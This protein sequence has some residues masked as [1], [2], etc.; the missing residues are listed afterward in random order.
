VP[1][2]WV[3]LTIG[4]TGGIA[5]GKTTVSRMFEHAGIPVICLDEL[6]RY[7]VKPGSPA[8][9]EIRRLFGDEVIDEAGEL[10]RA[11][12]A[13]IVFQDDGKRKL[14]ESIIHPKVNEEMTRR[15]VELEHL[16]HRT[17]VVDV[18]LLYEVRWEGAFDLVVVVYV[19]RQT[20]EERLMARDAMSREEA[21]SRLDAQMSIEEKR[22]RADYV[23]EN[24]DSL[25]RTRDQVTSIVRDLKKREAVK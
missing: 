18:P 14:L 11:A 15:A 13:G 25:D 17:V 12:V 5:S 10:D 1:R 20:Q 4:L 22:R 8:L 6:A 19:P 7:V 9:E 3:V 2:R 16:G 24:T 23:V 21:D